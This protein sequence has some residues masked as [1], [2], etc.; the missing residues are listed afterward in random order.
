MS[1]R[2]LTLE[3]NGTDI[4]SIGSGSIR[5]LMQW[6]LKD[7]GVPVR[8]AACMWMERDAGP[9][10]RTR[11]EFTSALHWRCGPAPGLYALGTAEDPI[12]LTGVLS[13]PGRGRGLAEGQLTRYPAQL[14]RGVW[15][16]QRGAGAEDTI[17][18]VFRH[19]PFRHPHAQGDGVLVDDATPRCCGPMTS[20]GT[21]SGSATT[22][23]PFPWMPGRCGGATQ[24]VPTT[25]RSTRRPGQRGQRWRP[26]RP[27]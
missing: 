1:Y 3:G 10:A 8:T 23:L 12:T 17:Q 20:R 14:Q 22:A 19:H 7:A 2:S 9:D 21:P 15:W 25:R 27:G 26:V 6:D 24:A 4:V 11:L 16:S 18:R 5:S 13:Q